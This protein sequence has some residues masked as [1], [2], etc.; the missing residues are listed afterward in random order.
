VLVEGERL[1]YGHQF[2]PAFATEIS[3]IDPLPHQRIAVYDR[4]LPQPRL[5]FL[6]A[7]DA[8]AGKTIMTGLYVRESLTRRTLRRVLVVVPAGLVGNWRREL[9]SLFGLELRIVTSGDAKA[10]NPFIGEGSDLVVVSIDSLRGARLFAALRDPAVEPYDLVVFDEAHKLACHRDPDGTVRA[11]ERYQLA[12]LPVARPLPATLPWSA[13]H[14]LLLTAAPHGQALSLLR[15][16]EAAG[17][18]L[19][20][21]QTAFRRFPAKALLHPPGQEM[22]TWPASRCTRCACATP[23]ATP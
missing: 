9:A 2:N 15:P 10:G 19:L 1:S 6:L 21:T 14:L 13:H 22:V 4:M 20:S 17:A 3:R 18:D 12:A 11:T 23:T 7:D 5:R 8:G 16:V